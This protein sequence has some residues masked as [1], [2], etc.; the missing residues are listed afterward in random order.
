MLNKVKGPII[1]KLWGLHITVK[2]IVVAGPD[3]SVGIMS[4]Y[5]D[6]AHIVSITN[7]NGRKA[8]KKE[9]DILIDHIFENSQ[10]LEQFE[11][12]IF[13]VLYKMEEENNRAAYKRAKAKGFKGTYSDFA[14]EYT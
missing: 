1:V 2:D 3:R 12:A 11:E 8:P 9:T 14:S 10:A 5:I 13:K 7:R 4:E 6:D